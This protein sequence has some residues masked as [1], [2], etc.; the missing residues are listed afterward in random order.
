MVEEIARL[1]ADRD[2]EREEM[3]NEMRETDTNPQRERPPSQ[4]R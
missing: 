4:H 3:I 1:L 2:N